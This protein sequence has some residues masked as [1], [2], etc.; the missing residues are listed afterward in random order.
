MLA[1][2][3]NAQDAK[4]VI[5][6]AAAAEYYA[7]KAKLGEDAIQYAHTIK[8]DAMALLGGFLK[9]APKNEGG[10][11]AKTGCLEQPVSKPP[12]LAELGLTKEQSVAAQQI[13]VLRQEQ[14]KVYEQLRTGATTIQQVKREEKEE[15]RQEQRVVNAQLVAQA[16][17]TA[18]TPHGWVSA[19]DDSRLHQS[20]WAVRPVCSW[21]MSAT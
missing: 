19:R 14:P 13:H 9:V 18:S 4:R 11:P 5:D 3:R 7:Q 16:P 21:T 6:M 17:I 12:T 20:A 1:E 8:T 10:R 2:V 15:K